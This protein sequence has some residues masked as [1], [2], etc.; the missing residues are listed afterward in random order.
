MRRLV[1]PLFVFLL[2]AAAPVDD[3][4]RLLEAGQERPA[5]EI[6]ERSASAGDIDAPCHSK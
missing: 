6:V 3:A 1:L 2:V 5:F 4:Q